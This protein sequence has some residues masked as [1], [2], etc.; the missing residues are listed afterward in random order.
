MAA[1][2][3]IT[4]AHYASSYCQGGRWLLAFEPSRGRYNILC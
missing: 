3:P 2:F 1:Y 4:A